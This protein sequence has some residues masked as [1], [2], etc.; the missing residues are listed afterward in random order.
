MAK[1]KY[2]IVWTAK[3]KMDLLG[4]YNYLCTKIE[5]PKAFEVIERIVEKVDLLST[6]PLLGQKEPLLAKLKRDYRR[7][8]EGNYKIIYNFRKDTI[9]VNRIFDTRQNPEKLKIR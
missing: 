9:Y 7:L 2:V 8:L 4:I 6:M 3:S 5:E 1:M